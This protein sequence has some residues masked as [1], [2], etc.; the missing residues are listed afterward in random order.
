MI[1]LKV[2]FLGLRQC[3]HKY[4]LLITL[5]STGGRPFHIPAFSLSL[6]LLSLDLCPVNSSCLALRQHSASSLQSKELASDPPP[7]AQPGK[8]LKAVSWANGRTDLVCFSS[9]RGCCPLLPDF[10]CLENKYFMSFVLFFPFRGGE[11]GESEI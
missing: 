9:L 1:F 5:L 4:T 7:G 6:S 10:Q 2:S 11:K 3:L 8:S